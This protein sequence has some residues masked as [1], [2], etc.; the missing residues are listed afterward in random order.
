MQRPIVAGVLALVCLFLVDV[1]PSAKLVAAPAQ[2]AEVI[3]SIVGTTDLHGVASP[4]NAFGGLPL[5]AGY[6]NNLR[7]A[8]ASD[9][10][11]VV[12]LDSG[13]TFQ[14]DVESNLSEGALIVAAYNAIGY[15]AE[16]IGNHD[17]DFG[18]VDSPQS[19]QSTGIC[20][21][22]QSARGPGDVSLPCGEPDR[23]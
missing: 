4:R 8:R 11:A 23:R 14:G 20:A 7:A 6:V 17:F 10:G 21:A 9:G 3:L 15:T 22:P 13:D 5:L 19:R 18:S 2:A 12:L 16:A 1:Q